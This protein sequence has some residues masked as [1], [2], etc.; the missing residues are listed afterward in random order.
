MF[1]Y[2]L[3][4]FLVTFCFSQS[5]GF[6]IG[7]DLSSEVEFEYDGFGSFEEELKQPITIGF[8][9]NDSNMGFGFEYQVP[10]KIKGMTDAKLSSISAYALIPIINQNGVNFLG[11]IGYS[12]PFFQVDNNGY[13]D[14]DPEI[15]YTSTGGLMYGWQVVYQK[16]G[17]SYT[18]YSAELEMEISGGY[19][20]Y[21]YDYDYDYDYEIDLPTIDLNCSRFT[22]SYFISN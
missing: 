1:R 21:D 6:K 9:S 17:L 11:K 13:D 15:K 19:N 18:L 7:F 4:F 20:G 2:L 3:P 12:L 8:D 10:S 22:I 5:L 14:D 16:F